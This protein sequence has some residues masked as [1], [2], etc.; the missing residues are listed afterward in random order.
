LNL[1]RIIINERHQQHV[2][3]LKEAG[4]NRSFP[5][6]IGFCEATS[7]HRTY[8]QLPSSRPLTHDVWLASLVA[9]A[10]LFGRR[11]SKNCESTRISPPYVLFI[12][13]N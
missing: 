9:V 7:I 13:V 3:I 1:C 10:L 4:G 8:R 5:I 2:I 6:V 11:V 12:L